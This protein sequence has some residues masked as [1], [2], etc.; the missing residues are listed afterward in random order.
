MTPPDLA[1]KSNADL[2]VPG[3]IARVRQRLYLVESTVAP[4]RAG[5]ST[6]VSLSCVDDDAQGQRLE[7]LWE[8]EIDPRDHDRRG[9]GRRSPSAGFDPPKLFAAYLNTLRW[10]CVTATDP[11]LFQSPF[12]AGIRSTPTSSSRC[13]RPFACPRVNLFIADDVGLGK[14]I[15][16]GLIARELLLRKKAQEIVVSCPPSML[17]QWKDELENRFGLT[18]EILDKDYMQ[19]RPPRTRLRRQSL[20]HALAVSGL[21]PPADRRSLR[22]PAARLAGRLPQRLAPHPRRSAPRGPIER[23]ALRHRL[24]DHAGHPRPCPAVRASP[25]PVGHAAQRPLQQLLRPAGDPRSAALLPRRAGH[26]E[27]CSTTSWSAGSRT[28]SGR[29]RAAFPSGASS[30]IDIDGCR[31]MPPNC[32]SRPCLTSTGGS[33]SNGSAARPNASR[34]P[35]ACSLPDCSSGCFRR[36]RPSPGRFAFT[37]GRSSGS[38]SWPQSGRP[39]RGRNRCLPRADLLGGGRRQR[40]RPG[41]PC[42]RKSFTPRRNCRCRRVSDATVGRLPTPKARE[43]FAREQKLLDEMTEI[44][45]EARSLA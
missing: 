45:E 17:F 4:P 2:P 19:Q 9:V 16:A 28:T 39:T 43:L 41:R 5:D 23:P 11:E 37:A 10:N 38:G 22:R 12:R 35:P 1:R 42:P 44:A 8:R 40:R 31:P 25:V 18:F 14:T 32:G 27:K 13:A 36:S 21:A 15:E 3:Q 29:S 24:P 34:P 6:L 26:E 30:Q 20:E 33:A 7:V